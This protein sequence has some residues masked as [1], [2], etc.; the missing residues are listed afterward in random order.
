MSDKII[1]IGGRNHLNEVSCAT[2]QRVYISTSR[3]RRELFSIT[4]NE[5]IADPVHHEV[6]IRREF[7][8]RLPD[9]I[10][11]FDPFLHGRRWERPIQR[12]SYLVEENFPIEEAEE[13]IRRWASKER[14][15]SHTM[16]AN[17]GLRDTLLALESLLRR[18]FKTTSRLEWLP[19]LGKRF[20]ALNDEL[21]FLIN[22]EAGR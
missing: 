19:I 4:P 5:P 20:Q 22:R 7:V 14:A 2:H 21:S 16:K 1:C 12:V 8:Y 10:L 11:V 13:L 6:Y 3:N 17:Q 15:L 9:C 18:F